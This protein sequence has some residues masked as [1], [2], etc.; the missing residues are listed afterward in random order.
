MVEIYD[1]CS[2]IFLTSKVQNLRSASVRTG[3]VPVQLEASDRD[4]RFSPKRGKGLIWT[5]VRTGRTFPV[6]TVA[7]STAM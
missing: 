3:R 7:L 4:R 2:T 6:S 5:A 1:M